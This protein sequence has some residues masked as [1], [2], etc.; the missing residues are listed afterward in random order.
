MEIKVEAKFI[1]EDRALRDTI[2]KCIKISKTHIDKVLKQYSASDHNNI[3]TIIREDI[4]DEYVAVLSSYNYAEVQEREDM[5]ELI[6]RAR[7]RD[8]NPQGSYKEG[9]AEQWARK[10]TKTEMLTRIPKGQERKALVSKY[11]FKAIYVNTLVFRTSSKVVNKVLANLE[12]GRVSWVGDPRNIARMLR[13]IADEGLVK[14][15]ITQAERQKIYRYASSPELFV[16]EAPRR[17]Y[18]ETAVKKAFEKHNKKWINIVKKDLMKHLRMINL[19]KGK[20]TIP[21]NKTKVRIMKTPIKVS[22]K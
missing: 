14:K 1:N 18:F 10:S 22:A 3:S 21:A 15:F 19:P 4:L 17:P 8:P 6:M 12:Y 5:T 13:R 20:I 16:L 2:S 11:K 7:G 9:E